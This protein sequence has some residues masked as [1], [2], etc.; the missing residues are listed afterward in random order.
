MPSFWTRQ[1]AAWFALAESSF[2][3]LNVVE[4]RRQFNLVLPFLPADAVEDLGDILQ[5]AA[6]AANPYADLREELVRRYTPGVSERLN[7]IIFAP[8]LGGQKPSQLMRSL[9]ASLPPAEPPG[10]L[11]KQHFV[12]RLPSD[13]QV[14]VGKK[15]EQLDARQ[16]AEYADSRWNLRNARK[17]APVSLAVDA[18]ASLSLEDA[19]GAVAAVSGRRQSQR[20]T[21]RGGQRKPKKD[22]VCAKHRRYGVDAYACEDPET[23][24]FPGNA[25]SGGH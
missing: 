7:A 11:F 10:L 23:C 2:E 14:E 20:P 18:V 1:P 17:S 5:G 9:L 4:P 8:E 19:D 16:L 13:L 6:A 21:R 3:A 15:L 24:Q 12:L 22:A 25:Q